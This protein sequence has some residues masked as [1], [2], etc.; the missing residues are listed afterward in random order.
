MVDIDQDLTYKGIAQS[1]IGSHDRKPL[2]SM[3]ILLS[4]YTQH[5]HTHAHTHSALGV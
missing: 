3:L 2:G 4:T 5:V 1:G